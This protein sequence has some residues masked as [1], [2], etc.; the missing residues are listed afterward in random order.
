MMY[1]TGG[2]VAAGLVFVSLSSVK[3]VILV[4]LLTFVQVY[5]PVVSVRN[6]A[7]IMCCFVDSIF[8]GC[9][10]LP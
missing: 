4:S 10:W 8:R 3:T 2:A 9:A 1:L 5:F 7:H 6:T